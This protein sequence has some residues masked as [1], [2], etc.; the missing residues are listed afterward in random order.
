MCQVSYSYKRDDTRISPRFCWR[1][2]TQPVNSATFERVSAKRANISYKLPLWSRQYAK[3]AARYR[4]P[5]A[6]R[7]SGAR[8]LG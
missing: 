8:Y 5:L 2:S 1:S 7:Y 4:W 6:F 3:R